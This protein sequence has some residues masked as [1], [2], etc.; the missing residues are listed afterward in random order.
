M[1]MIANVVSCVD[2]R[3]F[4]FHCK[5]GED[6]F[7]QALL[8]NVIVPNAHVNVPKEDKTDDTK[9]NFTKN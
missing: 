1:E 9:D 5:A 6:I 2:T 4:I 3:C 7:K 8:I